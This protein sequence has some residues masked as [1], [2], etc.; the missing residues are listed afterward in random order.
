MRPVM[1]R[2]VCDHHTGPSQIGLNNL[3][4]YLQRTHLSKNAEATKKILD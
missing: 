1:L 3:M 2:G 4:E